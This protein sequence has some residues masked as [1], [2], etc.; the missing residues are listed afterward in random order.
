MHS[1]IIDMAFS[2]NDAFLQMWSLCDWNVSLLSK[3]APKRFS[4]ELFYSFI[5]FAFYHDV[6]FYAITINKMTLIWVRF[7][8]VVIKPFEVSVLTKHDS[9]RN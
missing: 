7:H 5:L 1:V 6:C 9:K 8:L 2:F 4:Q 3:T